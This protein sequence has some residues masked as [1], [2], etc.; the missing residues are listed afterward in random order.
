MKSGT[1][2]VFVFVFSCPLQDGWGRL[3]SSVD[4]AARHFGNKCYG[5]RPLWDEGE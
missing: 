4:V 2:D 5:R 1:N 3:V